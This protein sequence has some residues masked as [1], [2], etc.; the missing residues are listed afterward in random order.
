MLFHGFNTSVVCASISVGNGNEWQPNDLEI[1]IYE[2]LNFA[3]CAII[4]LLLLSVE[5]YKL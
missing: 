4:S 2:V 1:L 5:S 3:V